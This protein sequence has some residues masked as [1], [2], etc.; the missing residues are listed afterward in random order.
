MELGKK[1][2]A[3]GTHVSFDF[4]NGVFGEGVVCGVF[5]NGTPILG[6]G[7]IVR[8]TKLSI[9]YEYS[10]VS[11]FENQMELIPTV[12]PCPVQ[13]DTADIPETSDWSSA[14]QGKFY[15]PEKFKTKKVF[16]ICPVRNVDPI[17]QERI[18]EYVHTLESSGVKVRWPERDTSQD[19]PIG[20]EICYANVG[21]IKQADQ[22][23]VWWNKDS[24]GSRFDLGAAFALGKIIRV[25]NIVP[26]TPHKSFENVLRHLD[27][28][29]EDK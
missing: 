25:A 4:K 5:N 29:N 17:E 16:L 26:S 6:L 19:D 7:Y 15:R 18:V 2:L 14:E 10:T 23:H 1:Q 21:A 3:E 27:V 24:E 11:V 13:I 28:Q 20:I 8:P 9:P 22:V 12:D